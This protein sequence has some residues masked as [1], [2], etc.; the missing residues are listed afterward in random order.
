MVKIFSNEKAVSPVIGVMLMIVVTVV[1]AAA[2]SAYAGSMKNQE[3][4]PQATFTV[5]SSWSDGYIE[6]SHLGGDTLMHDNLY[7]QLQYDSSS[8]SGYVNMSN[9]TFMPQA[10]YLRPG[11]TAQVVFDP[12]EVTVWKQ[13]SSGT[14]YESTETTRRATFTGDD[15]KL[16]IYVGVPYKITLIDK[17][18]GQVVFSSKQTMNP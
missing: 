12:Q 3:S 8:T 6:L 17:T 11:D 13:D 4:A 9:V 2:V 18:T 14:W 5:K 10:D 7:M 1:L 15:I 16:S